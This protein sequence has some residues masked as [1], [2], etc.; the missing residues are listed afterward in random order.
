MGKQKK[1][2]ANLLREMQELEAAKQPVIKDLD[3]SQHRLAARAP[4]GTKI[5]TPGAGQLKMSGVI[6]DFVEPYFEAL[7]DFQQCSAFVPLAIVAWNTALMPEENHAE[8]ISTYLEI[9]KPNHDPI[10]V[11]GVRQLLEDLIEDKL[12]NFEEFDRMVID[13]DFYIAP[14]GEWRLSIVSKYPEFDADETDLDENATYE[15]VRD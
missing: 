1:K 8:A 14:D 13:Y 10:E 4:K 11:H 7:G 9:S 6:Q 2:K 12:E 15:K 5:V 3:A